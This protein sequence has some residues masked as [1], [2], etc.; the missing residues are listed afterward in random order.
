MYR[1]GANTWPDKAK[2]AMLR[3]AVVD[4]LKKKLDLK[5]SDELPSMYHDYVAVVQALE[6]GLDYINRDGQKEK[7]LWSSKDESS[8]NTGGNPMV[9]GHIR[10][11]IPGTEVLDDSDLY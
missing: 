9:I 4:K 3:K 10:R 1:S 2:I 8:G 5:N 11:I 6:S 7:R